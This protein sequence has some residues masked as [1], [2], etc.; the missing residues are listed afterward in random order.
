MLEYQE[1]TINDYFIIAFDGCQINE[2]NH[3]NSKVVFC[4]VYSLKYQHSQ[5][6]DKGIFPYLWTGTNSFM[7]QKTSAR[8][9]SVKT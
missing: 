4:S 7:K 3:F 8:I 1:I 6:G 9:H 2:T 5:Q